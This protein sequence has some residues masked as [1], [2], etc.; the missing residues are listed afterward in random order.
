MFWWKEKY[1]LNKMKCLELLNEVQQ[2]EQLAKRKRDQLEDYIPNCIE[3]PNA[4]VIEDTVYET[5][6]LC[7]RDRL[8]F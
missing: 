4:S 7:R 1:I 3:F 6:N 5:G 2:R 8:L